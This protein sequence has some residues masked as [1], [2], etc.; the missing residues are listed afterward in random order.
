M[1]YNELKEIDLT[2]FANRQ[3]AK[4]M[5]EKIVEEAD[6]NDIVKYIN[7]LRYLS[8]NSDDFKL[9]D[10]IT[11][12]LLFED[13]AD[14]EREYSDVDFGDVKEL[15]LD[16][17]EEFNINTFKINDDEY[18]CVAQLSDSY[19]TILIAKD[20]DNNYAK[21]GIIDKEDTPGYKYIYELEAETDDYYDKIVDA[22]IGTRINILSVIQGLN[23]FRKTFTK[24]E[25]DIGYGFTKSRKTDK[26]I[27]SNIISGTYLTLKAPEKLLGIPEIKKEE[28]KVDKDGDMLHP[29]IKIEGDVQMIDGDDFQKM[30]D[31]A[32]GVENLMS[33]LQNNL[34]TNSIIGDLDIDDDMKEMLSDA[35]ILSEDEY[36][37]KWG[38]KIES[39]K[40][41][42]KE[43]LEDV[44]EDIFSNDVGHLEKLLAKAIKDEDYVLAKKLSDKIEKLGK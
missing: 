3:E 2:S 9:M 1:K 7:Y 22:E 41:E 35:I 38:E 5:V 10:K 29:G 19:E 25:I 34:A 24:D 13:L 42:E 8:L 43:E 33:D 21:F 15:I 28:K 40:K 39:M 20:S 6:I 4:E 23:S 30:I 17:V 36:V 44:V 12:F 11:K 14:I 37:E 18:N 16:T 27:L 31:D 26:G 32:G